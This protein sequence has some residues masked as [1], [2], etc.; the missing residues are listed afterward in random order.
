M[1]D[2]V[3]LIGTGKDF[4]NRTPLVQ[5][6]RST[7]NKWDLKSFSKANDT[8]IPTKRQPTEREKNFPSYTSDRGLICR[9]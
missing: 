5:A 3:E 9:I 6:P 7:I 2:S 1:G 8:I 4:L